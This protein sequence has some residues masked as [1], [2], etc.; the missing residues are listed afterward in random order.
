MR[1]KPGTRRT[2]SSKTIKD[3]R[4]ATRKQYSAEENGKCKDSNQQAPAL[5]QQAVRCLSQSISG[6]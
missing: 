5:H 4:R 1:P 6:D 2:A 3:I